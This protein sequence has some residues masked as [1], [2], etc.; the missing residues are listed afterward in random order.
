[1]PAILVGPVALVGRVILV[2]PATLAYPSYASINNISS[3]SEGDW[4]GMNDSFGFSPAKQEETDPYAQAA[5]FQGNRF[6]I[7]SVFVMDD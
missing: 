6:L 5:V 4:T 7:P 1:M 3:P 2:G